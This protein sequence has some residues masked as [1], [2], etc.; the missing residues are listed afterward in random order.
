MVGLNTFSREKGFTA[1]VAIGC[2]LP[3]FLGPSP[4]LGV[5]EVGFL[6]S[7]PKVPELVLL[8]LM[9]WASITLTQKAT[10]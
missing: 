9:S 5:V 1:E 4:V 10:I 6:W 7:T 3:D 2:G 8:C